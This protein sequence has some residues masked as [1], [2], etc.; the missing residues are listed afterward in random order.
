MIKEIPFP[1]PR[2]VILSPNHITNTVPAVKTIIAVK[3]N[4]NSFT[5]IACGAVAIKLIENAI[6]WNAVITTVP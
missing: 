2:S 1:I 4:A 3:V 5:T 6:A